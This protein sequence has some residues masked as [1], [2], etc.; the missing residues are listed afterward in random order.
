MA[1]NNTLSFP[2]QEYGRRVR[3]VQQQA[4]RLDLDVML[5]TTMASV[6]YLSGIESV[7]PHK[8]WLVAVPREG[9]PLLFCQDFESHNAAISSW[10]PAEFTYPVGEDS[11]SYV[12]AM[13]R[14]LGFASARIGLESGYCWSSLSVQMYAR[15]KQMLPD[16]E[17]VDATEAVSRAM[18]IKSAVE[19]QCVRK[20]AGIT[21][22]AMRAAIETI[23]EGATDNDVAAAAY[24]AMIGG[25]SEYSA[26]PVI[27]TTGARSGIP[28]STFRR[29]PICRGDMVFIEIA[30][31]INRY[32]APMMRTAVLNEPAPQVE[33][34]MRAAVSSVNTMIETIRP[35]VTA[36]MV[37]AAAQRCL[38]GLP[39][40]IV[41]HGY[42]GY[43]VGLGF[44]PEWSDCPSLLIRLGHH[45][46]LQPGM[47]FHCS[48]SLRDVGVRG[49]TCC[50]TIL[51]T[52]EG[53]EVLTEG[54]RELSI[55]PQC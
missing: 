18:S 6:C 41:W 1:V 39:S 22:Q 50:E 26:L 2:T 11:V 10:L 25:G 47:V 53:C 12:V 8:F 21:S 9:A 24:A 7:S 5:A 4:Q 52:E 27:V 42:Y 29:V 16:A 19:I 37:A 17:F 43:S 23:R 49:V 44:P 13:L 51:V 35:G 38:Q 36:H 15:M 54:K 34:L 48:T 33:G 31:A 30:A 40:E 3:A 46:V 28:H 20:A 45:D 55:C 32:H 14:K